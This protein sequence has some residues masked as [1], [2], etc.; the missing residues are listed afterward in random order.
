MQGNE[1]WQE[2]GSLIVDAPLTPDYITPLS[3][4]SSTEGEGWLDSGCTLLG[5][6]RRIA[7]GESTGRWTAQQLYATWDHRALRLAWIGGN[8]SG[9]GDLFLYLDTGPGGTNGTFTPYPVAVTGTLVTLPPEIQADA[10][11]W[12]QDASTAS[13]LRWHGTDWTVERQLAGEQFR[14]NGGRNGD[15]TDLYLP[16]ELLGLNAGGPLGVL[17]FAAEEPAPDDWPA[18]LGHAAGGQSGEQ[19]T[20]QHPAVACSLREHHGSPPRLRLDGSRRRCVPQRHE[21]G[22]AG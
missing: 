8:W 15:Q 7:R 4:L 18:C 19:R 3:S 20:G 11:I 12:V 22:A 10:L 6:D 2:F 13:L 21:W 17:A 5:A 9:D 1:R 16:F 14:F